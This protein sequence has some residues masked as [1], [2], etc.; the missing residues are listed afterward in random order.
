MA[1]IENNQIKAEISADGAEL[2]RLQ[3]SSG[4][5]FLWNGDATWWNGRAPLLFPIIGKVPNDR[6]VV[7]GREYTMR[8]HGFARTSHFV[9]ARADADECCFSLHSSKETRTQF[10]FDFELDVRYAIRGQSLLTEATVA[11]ICDRPMP[12][13]FGFHP[14][15]RWPLPDGGPK[16]DHVLQFD[17]RE[18][19]PVRRLQDGLLRL[20][21][22]KTPVEGQLLHLSDS[23]FEEGAIVFDQL[24]SRGV[25]YIGPSGQSLRVEFSGMPHLGVWTKPGAGF[26][27]I[28]PWQGYAA[29]AGFQGELSTKEAMIKISPGSRA[30]FSMRMTPNN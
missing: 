1:T 14:A 19:E 4:R 28:E 16:H 25:N 9:L 6:V 21:R 3:D 18:P 8:Q 20:E 30:T 24:K 23:L 26:I 13:S 22:C 11:N 27:C 2:V 7:D 17:Q 5:D 29:P 12:V 15:L 10:P